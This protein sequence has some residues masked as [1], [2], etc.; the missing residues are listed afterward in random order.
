MVSVRDSSGQRLDQDTLKNLLRDSES[1][2]L[3]KRLSRLDSETLK[4][5]CLTKR[6]LRLHSETLKTRVLTKS[7]LRSES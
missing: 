1:R 7:N 3:T 6:L 5:R 4:D 2:V